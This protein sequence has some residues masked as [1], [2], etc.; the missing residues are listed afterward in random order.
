MIDVACIGILVADSIV[1]TVDHL[2]E[3]GKLKLVD[4]I[5][6]FS[7]G[8]AMSAAVDLSI[9]GGKAALLGKCGQDGFGRFLKGELEKYNINLEGMIFDESVD[10]SAS[11]VLLDK[12][13]E[14]SFLCGIG[15][16]GEYT[17][18]DID[19]DVIAQSN[20]V[21]VAGTFLMPKF[22]GQPCANVMK[23]VKEMGKITV[24]DVVWDDTGKWM[25][26]I[27]PSLKYI[28]YFIPS[29][30][31]A[32]KLSNQTKPDEMAKVFFDKGVKH[33]VI[34]MGS[35]GSYVQTEPDTQGVLIPAYKVKA[36]DTTGAGDSFCAGFTYGLSHG[37]DAYEAADFANAVGAHCVMEIGATSGIRP[38]EDMIQF[39]EKFEGKGRGK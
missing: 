22:D 27:E 19:Y 25:K 37:M 38:Y 32:E 7:G 13:G 10:T 5:Q 21:F 29:I 11:I 20:I 30:E 3:K 1:Q 6:L 17:D 34:K 4:R 16:N 24:L 28:D 15:G 36:L 8:C 35:S 31:E 12:S 14:R 26:T 18:T 9:L 2:P 39:M 23:R 33:V